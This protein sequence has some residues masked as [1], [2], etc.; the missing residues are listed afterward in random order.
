MSHAAQ[1]ADA[2]AKE[3]VARRIRARLAELTCEQDLSC[4]AWLAYRWAA[5]GAE[6]ER[7]GLAALREA[8]LRA[9]IAWTLQRVPE[10]R[11][12]HLECILDMLLE[13]P[14]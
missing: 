12:V 5:P 6:P 4:L 2:E 10:R 1:I 3:A 7:A 8:Y 14:R 13:V 11:L 9:R